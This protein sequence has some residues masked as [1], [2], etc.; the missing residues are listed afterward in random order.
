MFEDIVYNATWIL[1]LVSDFRIEI[2]PKVEVELWS[3]YIVLC[4]LFLCLL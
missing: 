4:L 1:Y 2:L 3:D